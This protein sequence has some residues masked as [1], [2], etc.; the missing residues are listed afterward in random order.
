MIYSLR[1]PRSQSLDAFSLLMPVSGKSSDDWARF[2]GAGMLH[3]SEAPA[4]NT[5][6]ASPYRKNPVWLAARTRHRHG[7]PWRIP[8]GAQTE[9]MPWHC[10]D[11]PAIGS[12]RGGMELLRINESGARLVRRVWLCGVALSREPT[13]SVCGNELWR[14]LVTVVKPPVT[15]AYRN[16]N[17]PR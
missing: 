4:G 15:L 1:A 14:L 2:F 11:F 13:I 6:I 10:G 7:Q 9:V 5:G 3:H 12:T 17:R 16:K 8:V